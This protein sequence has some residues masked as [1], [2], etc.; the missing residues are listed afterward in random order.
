MIKKMKAPKLRFKADDG[1]EFP[2]WEEKRL[3]DVGTV[4]M[5]KRVFKEQTSENGE[6]PFFK[7]GT[8]GDKPDA[9]ISY[10]LFD[11][12]KTKYPYPQK[13]TVL[14]SASGTVGRQVIYNGEDAYY[15]DSNIVWLEHD[16]TIMDGFLK[17]FYSIVKW[18]G[19]E[20]STIKRLYNKTILDTMFYLPSLP[21]Q[22]KIADFLSTIDE[23]I[24]STESELTAW[25]ERKKGVMQKIFNREVRFKADDGSEFPEWEEKKMTQ[26]F[27]R[28]VE[29]NRTDLSPLTI[30]QGQ[31][32]VRRDES[33]RRIAYDKKGLKNYKAVKKDDFIVHLRSFEGG[34][35]IAN[36][37]G[38]VSP[39]Y[40]VYRGSGNVCPQFYYPYF[41]SNNFIKGRLAICVTGVR[42][43]K[44][45]EMDTF[46][47]LLLPC[48]SL[49]EQKK[50]ADCLSSL[51]DVI[52]QIN[53]E[54]SAWK[55][56][57]KGL[58]QQMFV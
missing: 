21:E 33:D 50:I 15:Q 56:F 52:N 22:Q 31:G 53:A 7:I 28:I 47:E 12:L 58:L 18:K 9:Y 45:I 1:S 37:D 8:F 4:A 3:G 19:L 55:E 14:L 23:I 26:L 36:Q 40:H 29:K 13:G 39:A 10:K 20:G 49:P 57:K 30:I 41:R 38:I 34:L 35:E 17:Q 54:L 16:A 27:T 24:Q 11:E 46:D 2:E 5:C 6:V 32:T 51:D 25:Q 48:P 42:D 44:N 43:G